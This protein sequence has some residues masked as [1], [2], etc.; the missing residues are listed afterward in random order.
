MAAVASAPFTATAMPA[1]TPALAAS[2]L[3]LPEASPVTPKLWLPVAATERFPAAL[4]LPPVLD[5]PTSARVS[6]VATCTAT[7]P[8]TPMLP[9]L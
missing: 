6:A 5:L 1:P 7:A 3:L 4:M 9:A 2:T 8:P